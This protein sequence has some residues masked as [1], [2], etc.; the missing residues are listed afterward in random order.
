MNINLG[1]YDQYYLACA[2]VVGTYLAAATLLWLSQ[3]S[4]YTASIASFR[5]IAQNFLTVIN[6]IFALN[7][8]FLANDT[9]NAHDRALNAVF[10][11]AGSLRTMRDLARHLPDPA[12]ANLDTAIAAYAESAVNAE[13]PMLARRQSSPEAGDALDALFT[14]LG[15]GEVTRVTVSSVH[16]AMLQQAVQVR[17]MRDQRIT[18]SRTHVNPLK[19]MGMA[20]LG[21][22]TMISI[23]MVHVDMPRAQ[24]LSV[25]LFATAAAPTAAI[26]LI[27]GNPFQEPMAVRPEPIARLFDS[28]RS[29]ASAGPDRLQSAGAFAAI[30]GCAAS[31]SPNP[32]PTTT[33]SGMPV[34]CA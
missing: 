2:V 4:R 25:L 29:A 27:H 33:S 13:W 14:L 3:R 34:A 11:E 16:A 7:L 21:L 26:I 23:A 1:A 30:G 8:A 12:R 22:L 10:Q 6:V 20:F 31:S 24:L 9:W 17:S 15:S 19:W 32:P 18:L 5:G 28:G